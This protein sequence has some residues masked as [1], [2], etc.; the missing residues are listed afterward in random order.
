MNVKKR[1]P[2]DPSDTGKFD[3]YRDLEERVLKD[4]PAKKPARS[5]DEPE[6]DQA[7]K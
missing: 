7:Q 6:Q 5:A 1:R 3:V 4:V 2:D